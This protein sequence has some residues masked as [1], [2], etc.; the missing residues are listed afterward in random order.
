MNI[1]YA[2]SNPEL[3]YDY[4]WSGEMPEFIANDP[5]IVAVWHDGDGERPDWTKYIFSVSPAL[6]ADKA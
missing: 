5:A 6:A 1:G 3:G 2:T 4:Q